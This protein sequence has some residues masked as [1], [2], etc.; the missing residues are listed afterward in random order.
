[1][2]TDPKR[3]LDGSATSEVDSLSRDLLTSLSPTNEE[4]EQLFG[5]VLSHVGLAAAA[6]AA[7]STVS[8]QAGASGTAKA[9]FALKAT[10]GKWLLPLLAAV[11]VGAGVGYLTLGTPSEPPRPPEAKASSSGT[12]TTE[13]PSPLP[14]EEPIPVM[15]EP[16]TTQS[17]T[18]PAPPRA[19]PSEISSKESALR[20]ENRLVR[21]AREQWKT[22]Q[23]EAALATLS[24]LSRRFPDG[25][26]LQEREMLRATI[27]KAP[28]SRGSRSRPADSSK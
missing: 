11:P 2:M 22:G 26:L 19:Q 12:V 8:A 13:N 7:A 6:G 25:V 3:I 23:S 4:Q 15:R 5:R 10:F 9:A 17:Q 24:E 21:K 28:T 1:M 20:E 27:S 18:D 14:T 16:D